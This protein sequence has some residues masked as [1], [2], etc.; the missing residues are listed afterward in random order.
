MPTHSALANGGFDGCGKR[1]PR[2][3]PP[4]RPETPETERKLM[5]PGAVLFMA[6][7]HVVAA[8]APYRAVG[9]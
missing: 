2:C 7:V 4:G 5:F 3:R 6:A 9:Q 1:E 8:G